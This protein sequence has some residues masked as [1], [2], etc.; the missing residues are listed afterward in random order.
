MMVLY[1][2]D[3]NSVWIEAYKSKSEGELIKTRARALK[4]IKDANIMPKHQILSPEYILRV[5]VDDSVLSNITLLM[6]VH[7]K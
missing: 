3:S 5:S 1:H 6:G 2:V 7:R 4:R